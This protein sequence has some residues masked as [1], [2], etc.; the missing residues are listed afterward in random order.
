MFFWNQKRAA[1]TLLGPKSTEKIDNLSLIFT[2]LGSARVKA[3]NKIL[4]KLSPDVVKIVI[5]IEVLVIEITGHSHQG[6]LKGHFPEKKVKVL[7]SCSE[8]ENIF[9]LAQTKQHEFLPA[10]CVRQ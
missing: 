3:A 1:F 7:F 2:H 9:L 10:F 4:M 8:K 5:V 6:Q